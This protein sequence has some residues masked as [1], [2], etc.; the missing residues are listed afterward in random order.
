MQQLLCAGCESCGKNGQKNEDRK[1]VLEPYKNGVLW[2]PQA[3]PDLIPSQ[4]IKSSQAPAQRTGGCFRCSALLTACCGT[5]SLG[6][7][8][9]KNAVQFK[10]Y[11]LFIFVR[12]FRGVILTVQAPQSL[13][14]AT[15]ACRKTWC[16]EHNQVVLPGTEDST[17]NPVHSAVR[18]LQNTISIITE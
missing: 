11:R 17:M 16:C 7:Q 13:R 18:Q 8:D 15:Q 14:Y 3:L 9:Q 12:I 2:L 5:H 6:L 4:K 1:S 10:Y